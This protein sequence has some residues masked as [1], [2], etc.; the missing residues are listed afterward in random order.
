EARF[1]L[2]RGDFARARKCYEELNASIAPDENL[3]TLSMPVW[4]AAQSGLCEALLGLERPEEARSVAVASLAICDALKIQTFAYDIVRMLALAE[5]KLGLI[6]DAVARLDGLIAAQTALGVSGLRIGVTYEARAEVALWSGDAAAFETYARLTAREYRYGARCPLSARYERLTRE[7]RRRGMQVAVA[8]SDF[9]HTTALESDFASLSE[10]RDAVKGALS[11]GDRFQSALRLLCGARSA[12]GGHLFLPGP[13]GPQL[14]AT[15][16][17]PA[18]ALR[19][20]ARVREYLEQQ[21]DYF[22]TQTIAVVGPPA[23]DTT[24]PTAQVD[25]VEYE[26]L[27]LVHSHDQTAEI[28]GVIALAP[29]NSPTPYPRQA[30]LLASIAEQLSASASPQTMIG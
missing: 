6:P 15:H 30:L 21:E 8:P 7:A 3:R 25:G 23:N 10:L 11:A 2:I 22:D 20:T 13:L 19:L 18:P 17:L 12:R 1:E 16:E 29:G 28:T 9:G 14:A 5:A 27:L 24:A 26:L 4:V